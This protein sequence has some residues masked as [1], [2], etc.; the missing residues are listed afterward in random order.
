VSQGDLL[1]EVVT[2]RGHARPPA[3]RGAGDLHE[4]RPGQPD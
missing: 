2:L 3:E 1:T 4:G